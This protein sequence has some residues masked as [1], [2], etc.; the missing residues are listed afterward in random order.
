MLLELTRFFPISPFNPA[1]GN[2]KKPWFSEVFKGGQKG[3]SGK[4][5]QFISLIPVRKCEM[6]EIIIRFFI[7]G[8]F[9]SKLKNAFPW[10]VTFPRINFLCQ[11]I[12]TLEFFIISV[13]RNM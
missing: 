8:N 5:F 13:H 12:L 2:I 11:C 10:H 6:C 1:P 3:T 4:V 9:N 7:S